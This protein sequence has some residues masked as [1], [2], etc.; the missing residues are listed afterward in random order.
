M[1]RAQWLK[2]RKDLLDSVKSQ[3]NS[4]LGPPT[5]S[6]KDYANKIDHEFKK[7]W[8]LSHPAELVE[9][10]ERADLLFLSDFHAYYQSQRAHLR[11]LKQINL[12]QTI[13]FMECFR[14][15][16]SA[17]IDLFWADQVTEVEFLKLTQWEECWGFP[18]EHYRDLVL[19]LKEKQV[20][21]RGLLT[22]SYYDLRLKARDRKMAQLIEQELQL[23][24]SSRVVV[25]VGEK[26]LYKNHL[27][28][29]IKRR[30][31]LLFKDEVVIFQDNE[32]LYFKS[33]MEAPRWEPSVLKRK[34]NFCWNVSPPW[35]KWQSYLI[36]LE[37]T[38]DQ[39]LEEEDFDFEDHIKAFVSWMCHDLGLNVSFNQLEVLTPQSSKQPLSSI[40]PARLKELIGAD[41]SFLLSPQG[42]IYLSRP[43]VNHA[44]AMAGQYI[45]SQLSQREK[46]FFDLPQDIERRLWIES[47]GFFFSKWMNP[48]RKTESFE[49]L[50]IRLNSL[51]SKSTPNQ[52]M[53]LV[54]D[55]FV[56]GQRV[57]RGL[58][59]EGK[60]VKALGKAKE[61]SQ[62]EAARFLGRIFGKSLFERVLGRQIPREEL[63]FWLL[64]PL[65]S[66][67][68]PKTFWER[69]VPK[70][71]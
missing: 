38:V 65:E 58:Q 32:E 2:T 44:A 59:G 53:N 35:V 13:V 67:D 20:L 46:L 71:I 63:L 69:I 62:L 43:S 60:K 28:L 3:V 31:L 5:K 18:W 25:I 22:S 39:E 11:L 7:S 9:Q 10:A 21:V 34:N 61:L 33:Q 12:H 42:K 52:T 47:V 36:Y 45:H 40:P 55:I 41:R 6:L 17:A 56:H 27:P 50:K 30:P 66:E 1:K 57:K 70:L 49:D 64:I 14:A 68:F 23:Y 37:K 15:E 54:S 26:H 48:S 8:S 29:E 51:H 19:H 4:R 16:D 24:P